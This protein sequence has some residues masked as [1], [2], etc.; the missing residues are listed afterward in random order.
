[1]KSVVKVLTNPAKWLLLF[2]RKKNPAL[3]TGAACI[4]L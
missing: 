4:S 2:A 3:F 1:M